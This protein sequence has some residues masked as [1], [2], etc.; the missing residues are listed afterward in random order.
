MQAS[1]K[2]RHP[3]HPSRRSV[4]CARRKRANR[5]AHPLTAVHLGN[6]MLAILLSAAAVTVHAQQTAEP[7]ASNASLPDAP[8]IGTSVVGIESGPIAS[9]S[10]AVISGTVLDPN[11]NVIQDAHIA[12]TNRSGAIERVVQSGPNGQFAIADLPAGTFRLRITGKAMGTYVSPPITISAGE[13]YIATEVMLPIAAASTDVTVYGD[14]EE[15][16][17][18][19][20]H[21]A[22]EQ[23]VFGVFPNFY[24]A[25][26]WNAPPLGTRQKYKLALRAEIDP[27][28]FL[29]VAGIA[30]AEQNRNIFPG[31]G[32]GIQGYAKRYGAAYV[33]SFSGRVMSS[34]VFASMFHQDPRYFYKGTGTTTSR[35]FYAVAAAVITKDD[36]GRWKPN[37]SHVLG[38]FAAGALANLYYP[39]SSRGLSLC[40]TTGVVETISNAGNNL[41]REFL[42]KGI[43]SHVPIDANG[44]P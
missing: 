25:F 13:M 14:K 5:K 28:T 8:G 15:L 24:S 23:R 39:S 20:M 33:N 35:A 10:N 9:P 16:A 22:I 38:N 1:P 40:I 43:T 3:I 41:F 26:D 36:N 18:E 29:G 34:A 4:S 44:K 11:G 27:V 37:Y 42:L 6:M 21:I 12:L 2:L 32:G 30:A 31:Y 19:Q 17:E 7:I